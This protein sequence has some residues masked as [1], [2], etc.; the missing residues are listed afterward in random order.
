MMRA[1]VIVA[2]LIVA[3][4]LAGPTLA[5]TGNGNGNGNVGNG[6]GNG[7]TG[8]NNGNGNVGNDNGNNNT[9]N[10]NGNGYRSD[11][12]GNG[13][14]GNGVTNAGQSPSGE[15]QSCCGANENGQW[16]PEPMTI[17]LQKKKHGRTVQQFANST[18]GS[19]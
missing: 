3:L 13:A 17:P 1:F 11:G 15:G 5:G 2:S 4:G 19:R 12:N 18:P 8:N 16:T 7:N 10:G 6:N 14:T 9:G